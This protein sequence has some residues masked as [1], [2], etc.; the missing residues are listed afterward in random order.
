MSNQ[1][2]QASDGFPTDLPCLE[3]LDSPTGMKQ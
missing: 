1:K 3:K 2:D